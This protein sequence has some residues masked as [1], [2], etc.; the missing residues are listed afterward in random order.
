MRQRR[1]HTAWRDPAVICAAWSLQADAMS[2]A[3]RATTEALSALQPAAGAALSEAAHGGVFTR[4]AFWT[5]CGRRHQRL[6]RRR[7][8]QAIIANMHAL[9]GSPRVRRRTFVDRRVTGWPFQVSGHCWSLAV[10][11]GPIIIVHRELKQPTGGDTGGSCRGDSERPSP[12]TVTC[13]RRPT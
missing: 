4:Q 9:E 11:L 5:P 7:A 6:G 1:R 8:R 10:G 3:A 2:T 12:L 13:R